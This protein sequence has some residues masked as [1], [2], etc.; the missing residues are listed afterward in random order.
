[1]CGHEHSKIKEEPAQQVG[2]N[3]AI[4]RKPAQQVA[5]TQQFKEAAQQVA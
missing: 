2:M 3:I 1:M 4:Q 5:G